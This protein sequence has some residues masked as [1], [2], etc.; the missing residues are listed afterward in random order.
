MCRCHT[1]LVPFK[2]VPV[3]LNSICWLTTSPPSVNQ[4]SRKCGSLG[5]SQPYGPP[6]PLTGIALPLPSFLPL[7]LHTHKDS[8]SVRTAVV[9]SGKVINLSLYGAWLYW[10]EILTVFCVN[11]LVFFVV[12]PCSWETNKQLHIASDFRYEEQAKRETS[13]CS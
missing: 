1:S 12:M 10:I 7:A 8:I 13:R 5:I 3:N 6:W 11:S 4:P 2:F 9:Y